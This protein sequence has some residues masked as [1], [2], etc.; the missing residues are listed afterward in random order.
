[1]RDDPNVRTEHFDRAIQIFEKMGA[2][3][4]LQFAKR[5]QAGE[6]RL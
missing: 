2:V 4:E 3:H 1:L 6:A 5:A